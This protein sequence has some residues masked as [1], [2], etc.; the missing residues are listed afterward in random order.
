MPQ[1]GR[2]SR[3]RVRGG[4]GGAGVLAAERWWRGSA[5]CADTIERHERAEVATLGVMPGEAGSS[6]LRRAHHSRPRRDG[7]GRTPS[8]PPQA[9]GARG[10][11]MSSQGVTHSDPHRAGGAVGARVSSVCT[12]RHRNRKPRR[13]V[14]SRTEAEETE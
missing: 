1:D 6:Q 7:R 2:S 14:C 11:D 4:R 9:G 10:D 5:G 3:G 12:R 8:D 13:I